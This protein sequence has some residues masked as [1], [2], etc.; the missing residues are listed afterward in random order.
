MNIS[1]LNQKFTRKTTIAFTFLVLQLIIANNVHAIKLT[2]NG[3]PSNPNIEV[4]TLEDDVV[5]S[6]SESFRPIVTNTEQSFLCIGPNL[7]AGPTANVSFGLSSSDPYRVYGLVG[8]SSAIYDYNPVLLEDKSFN[9]NTTVDS[10]CVV[11]GDMKSENLNP[12]SPHLFSGGFE[13]NEVPPNQDFPDLN[14]TLLDGPSG[15]ASF[16]NDKIISHGN[17]FT[18]RYLLENIGNVPVTFDIADYFSIDTTA[19]SSQC[20]PTGVGADCGDSGTVATIHVGGVYLKNASLAS[21]SDSLIIEITR[22]PDITIDN[23]PGDLLVSALVTNAVDTFKQN[24]LDAK[25]LIGRTIIPTQLVITDQLATNTDVIAGNMINGLTGIEVEIQDVNGNT[26]VASTSQVS[27]QIESGPIGGS[28]VGTTTL[29]PTNGV[30]AFNNINI[31]KVGTYTLRISSN[32]LSSAISNSFNVTV[33]SASQLVITTQPVTTVADVL[34]PNIIVQAQDDFGNLDTNDNSQVQVSIKSFTGTSGATLSG[35]HTV[36]IV[37]GEATFSDLNINLV[38]N[39]YQFNF[40]SNTGLTSTTSNVFN[41]TDIATQMVIT[42][43]AIN[44]TVAGVTLADIVVE[45]RYANGNLDL[46]NNS[47]VTIVIDPNPSSPNLIGTTTVQAVNGI[48]TF[49]D[50]NVEKVGTNYT[51]TVSSGALST[52]TTNSFDIIADVATQLVITTQPVNTVENDSIPDVIVQAQDVYGNVDLTNNSMALMSI[53][54]FSGTTGAVL[55]GTNTVAVVNG[56]ATFTGLSID[57]VGTNY[58]LTVVSNAA[59]AS[60]DSTVFDV[61]ITP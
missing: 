28:L 20:S 54:A 45:L 7:A 25:T 11:K 48:A 46:T 16:P 32:G 37:S 57:L 36:S 6:Y 27:I 42:S 35:T 26:D 56:E 21:N 2:L 14:I 13:D 55:S 40:D 8:V 52:D 51:L 12:G 39:D 50:L 53:T 4:L 30:V 15:S 31:E 44:T 58:Q 10:Q 47:D 61:L 19:V 60:D 22:T 41:I 24:N 23:T 18:Y 3:Q 38:G 5:Y 34:M 49:D 17:S 1:K 9:I 59:L 43:S 29:V 33:G